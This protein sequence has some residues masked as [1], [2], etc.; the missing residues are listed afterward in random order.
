MNSGAS[1]H[2]L[3]HFSYENEEQIPFKKIKHLGRGSFGIVDEVMRVSGSNEP[4]QIYARKTFSIRAWR[5][6][7]TLA[8]IKSEID[9]AKSLD[10]IHV[11]KL[12][13]TYACHREYAMIMEPVGE[14]NLEEFLQEMSEDDREPARLELIQSW[15]ACLVG[16]VKYLH[17][18]QIHHRDIKPQNILVLGNKI[19]YT[20]FGISQEFK[21]RT[22]TGSTYTRGTRNYWAPEVSEY[23]RPGRKADIF[24]LGTVFLELLA[25]QW[26]PQHLVKIWTFRPYSENITSLH[27]F[28]DEIALSNQG[29]Q[30]VRQML[31]YICKAMLSEDAESRPFAKEI[32]MFWNMEPYIDMGPTH[33][34]CVKILESPRDRIQRLSRVLTSAVGERDT[35]L[36]SRLRMAMRISGTFEDCDN[37]VMVERMRMEAKA[38]SLAEAASK[39]D[40]K[41]LKD[42]LRME[43]NVKGQYAHYGSAREAA[44]DARLW[45]LVDRTIAQKRVKS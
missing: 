24:S 37:E 30:T 44:S 16:G 34:N 8:E 35:T 40:I 5:R 14:S 20:D 9:V 29:V 42:V 36:N 12:V 22:L 7:K 1:G 43:V 19:L 32:A 3:K 17:S 13:E 23:K 38:K 39:C 27:E 45:S 6:E 2:A 31:V 28:L 10:H 21:E 18:H 26:G 15:F 11:V 33:C 25:A 4:I 41:T